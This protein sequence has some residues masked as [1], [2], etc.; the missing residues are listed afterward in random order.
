MSRKV[1]PL[2]GYKSLKAFN[3]FHALLLGLKML[4]AYVLEPYETFYTR[5]VEK[6]EEEKEK[7]LKEAALFVTPEEDELEALVAFCTD[8]N[9]VP[10]SKANLK[11]LKPDEIHE[12][13]VAVCMEIGKIKIDL[14][15]EDEKKKF[16]T[17][18]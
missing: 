16:L 2:V 4:P 10:L 3:A 6:S 5:F 18:V 8:K 17:S 1:L 14:L 9:G 15:T 7:L 11:N 13:I 12:V